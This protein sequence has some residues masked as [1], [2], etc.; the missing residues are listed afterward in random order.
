MES[1]ITSGKVAA[2]HVEFGVK[3]VAVEENPHSGGDALLVTAD[4]K[5]R[6]L[7][8][9]SS[10]PNDPLNFRKWEKFGIILA[11]CWFC[12]LCPLGSASA[13]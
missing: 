3:E 9:P 5:I 6:K 1:P 13:T 2:K 10:D 12:K 11:C 7:P 8:V 4:G